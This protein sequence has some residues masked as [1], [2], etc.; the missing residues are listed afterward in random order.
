MLSKFYCRALKIGLA[1]GFGYVALSAPAP[2]AQTEGV[3]WELSASHLQAAGLPL[4]PYMPTVRD[5]MLYQVSL[6]THQEIGLEWDLMPGNDR[7]VRRDGVAEGSLSS[8]FVLQNR[9]QNVQGSART[10]TLTLSDLTLVTVAVTANGEVRGL[11][12]GPGSPRIPAEHRNGKDGYDMVD[13]KVIF[14]LFLPDDP[15]IEKLVFLLAHPNGT[16]YRLER[17]GTLDLGSRKHTP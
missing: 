13:S 1:C 2:K 8:N 3:S 11:T 17:V 10:S 14:D 16:K 5:V 7:P 9:K 6:S 15:K 12:I 4:P